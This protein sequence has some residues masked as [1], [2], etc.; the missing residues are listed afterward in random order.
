M[1][2]DD[3]NDAIDF[4]VEF[5]H[6]QC[7]SGMPPHLLKLKVGAFIMLLRNLNPK[8]GL[9]NGTRLI[10]RSLHR[11]CI[12]AEIITGSNKGEEICIPRIDLEP[13]E[14]SLLFRMKRRQFP[15]ILAFAMTINKSQGQ[16][17]DHVGIYL[18]EPVFAHEQLYVALTRVRYHENLK[19]LINDNFTKNIVLK[20]LCVLMTHT[21][22]MK[23]N[24]SKNFRHF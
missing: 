15:V 22:M 16:S 13:S 6:A 23:L 21:I 7:P 4:P 8:K 14:S 20:E 24:I 10:V 3:P 2:S 5:L 9:L 19:L 1:I 18:P 12:K 11:N 17:F